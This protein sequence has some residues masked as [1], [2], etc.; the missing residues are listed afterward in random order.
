MAD[1][2]N[3]E[4]LVIWGR[5]IVISSSFSGKIFFGIVVIPY[6]YENICINTIINLFTFVLLI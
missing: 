3:T 4:I 6:Y 5:I 2:Q 1:G